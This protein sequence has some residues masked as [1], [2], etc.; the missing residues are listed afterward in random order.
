M[1]AH[2]LR[3]VFQPV[4]AGDEVRVAFLIGIDLLDVLVDGFVAPGVEIHRR[5]IDEPAFEFDIVAGGNRL[6]QAFKLAAEV[7]IADKVRVVVDQRGGEK[8]RD[9]AHAF[10][11]FA[12]DGLP[13]TLRAEVEFEI[14]L[15]AK[16]N[17]KKAIAAGAEPW[18]VID[19]RVSL[20]VAARSSEQVCL[21]RVNKTG[22]D[23]AALKGGMRH[24]PAQK[25]DVGDPRLGGV[26]HSGMSTLMS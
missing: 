4:D 10:H 12:R 14:Q 3:R 17:L 5:H 1:H 24:H 25:L 21:V 7:F 2:Q 13:Q 26:A 8:R 6:D 16:L 18:F 15:V 9:F 20:S 11:F 19:H 23:L 22:E